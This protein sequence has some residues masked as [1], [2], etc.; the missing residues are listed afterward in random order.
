MCFLQILNFDFTFFCWIPLDKMS[1]PMFL[2]STPP[3]MDDFDDDLSGFE[4]TDVTF[5]NYDGKFHCF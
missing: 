4:T 2:S 5:N 3:P 1:N